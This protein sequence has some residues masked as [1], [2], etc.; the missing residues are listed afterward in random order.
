[1]YS[2]V[3]GRDLAPSRED[4]LPPHLQ[5]W[6]LIAR[7]VSCAMFARYQHARA[8]QEW[9][10]ARKAQGVEFVLDFLPP[11][12]PN[13]NLIERQ[14]KFLRKHALQQ[15]HATYEAMQAAVAKVLDNLQDYRQ[16]LTA[17]MAERLHLVP[18]MPTK[19]APV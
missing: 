2:P 15:W 13:L 17:L 12:S 19:T 14:W 9:V 6:L 8:V 5:S 7:P 11:Y 16:E 18:A 3:V 4:C 10:E 1:L